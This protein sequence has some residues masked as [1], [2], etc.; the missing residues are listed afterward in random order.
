MTLDAAF[1]EEMGISE[2]KQTI[3][4]VEN[5]SK[6]K[7]DFSMGDASDGRVRDNHSNVINSS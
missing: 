4:M 3:L 6:L 1:Q 7:M 5:I 2:S